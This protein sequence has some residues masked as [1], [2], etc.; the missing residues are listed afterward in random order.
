MSDPVRSGE[1][2]KMA[3][4]RIDDENARGRYSEDTFQGFDYGDIVHVE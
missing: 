1:I 4:S 2:F 3:K